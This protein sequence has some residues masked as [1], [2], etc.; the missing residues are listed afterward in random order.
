MPWHCPACDTI[1][2][3]SEIELRPRDGERYR[4]HTCRLTLD[5]NGTLEKFVVPPF[6]TEQDAPPAERSRR[7][8]T[9][10]TGRPRRKRP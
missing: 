6:E 4:C 2:R 5:F 7:V 10:I 3:H 1:I 8:P 9:P